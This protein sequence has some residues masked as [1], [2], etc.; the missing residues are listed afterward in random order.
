VNFDY[1]DSVDMDVATPP[2]EYVDDGTVTEDCDRIAPT[3]NTTNRTNTITITLPAALDPLPDGI[4]WRLYRTLDNND[5]SYSLLQ[6]VVE[7]TFEGS[8][9]ITTEFVDSGFEV[10]SGEP[11]TVSYTFD[12]PSKI[13]LTDGANVQGTLPLGM[14]HQT[15]TVTLTVPGELFVSQGALVWRCPFANAE[16]IWI[17]AS[18]GRD[19]APAADDVI[20][21]IQRYDSV[22]ETYDTIFDG[23]DEPTVPVGDQFGPVTYP[24]FG[25]NA[26]VKHDALSL[27]IVQT[28]GGATPTDYD[29]TVTIHMVVTVPVMTSYV[30][31]ET[32][33]ANAALG[34]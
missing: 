11:P 15:E 17:A 8:G 3:T 34:F 1:L 25:L 32:P 14:M 23:G 24:G 22:A 5:W 28:G 26:L 21:D 27:D 31:D 10:T 7:E 16:I 6:D 18:L 9:I 13:D 33:G 12:N 29:L 30:Y 20:V 19:S 2:D 4:H